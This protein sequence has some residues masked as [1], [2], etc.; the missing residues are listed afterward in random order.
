MTWLRMIA[1]CAAECSRVPEDSRAYRGTLPYAARRI[2]V[3]RSL[4][5]VMPPGSSETL[6]FSAVRTR[7]LRD[8][9]PGPGMNRA[10]AR[11]GSAACRSDRTPRISGTTSPASLRKSRA[12]RPLMLQRPELAL[13][14]PA[15]VVQRLEPPGAQQRRPSVAVLSPVPGATSSRCCRWG[16]S[17]GT[18]LSL[19]SGVYSNGGTTLLLLTGRADAARG[20]TGSQTASYCLPGRNEIATLRQTQDKCPKPSRSGVLGQRRRRLRRDD[21][22]AMIG[23]R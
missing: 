6:R 18:T 19:K 3:S 20:G 1:V 8:H 23:P 9:E 7:I 22:T 17:S 10:R 12:Q 14:R 21:R 13:N 15:L 16:S 4:I 11:A 2:T 5:G